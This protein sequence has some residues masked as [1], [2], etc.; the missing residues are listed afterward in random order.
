MPISFFN[1]SASLMKLNSSASKLGII[2]SIF[3]I[4][5]IYFNARKQTGFTRRRERNLI[6]FIYQIMHINSGF[7]CFVRKADNTHIKLLAFLKARI[8]GTPGPGLS[9][10]LRPVTATLIFFLFIF[11]FNIH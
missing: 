1:V 11:L 6:S 9:M 3:S 5:L 2:T 10:A 8:T 7:E 4:E